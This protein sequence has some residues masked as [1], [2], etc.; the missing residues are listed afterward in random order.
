MTTSLR[1]L[2]AACLIAL[3]A[4]GPTDSGIK[5]EHAHEA[6]SSVKNEFAK[7]LPAG[8]ETLL[9]TT[10]AGFP[11]YEF[12]DENGNFVGLDIDLIN[13]IAS[14]QGMKVK[15]QSEPF[16]NLFSKIA[17]PDAHSK[18]VLV[19]AI[20]D[21]DERRAAYEL[22]NAYLSS[23][24]VIVV[25]ADSPIK[26]AR[27]LNG[28]K[29]SAVE[30]SIMIDQLKGTGA[31]PAELIGNTTSYINFKDVVSGKSDAAVD[32]GVVISYHMKNHPEYK[33]RSIRLDEKLKDGLVIASNKGN[34]DLI[35][36]INTGLANIKQNGTYDKILNKWVGSK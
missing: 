11:P 31:S 13:A 28:K 27:D 16:R 17:T 1:I 9:V 2:A 14:D 29:V 8:A 21:S 22:S 33:L 20:S 10:D 24:T 15:I 25:K 18:Q 6:K 7:D 3:T 23:P 30:K 32:D 35:N 36:K 19:S 4:C 26:S 12:Q 5:E 34:T